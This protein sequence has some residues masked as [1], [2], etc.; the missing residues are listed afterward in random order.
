MLSY[1]ARL[2]VAC[3]IATFAASPYAAHASPLP[4]VS[5]VWLDPD[6]SYG[7][8]WTVYDDADQALAEDLIA[9]MADVNELVDLALDGMIVIRELHRFD[10]DTGQTI[11]LYKDPLTNLLESHNGGPNVQRKGCRSSSPTDVGVRSGKDRDQYYFHN[12]SEMWEVRYYPGCEQCWRTTK[13]TPSSQAYTWTDFY[14]RSGHDGA[15]HYWNTQKTRTRT[16]AVGLWTGDSSINYVH[17][18]C[19]GGVA[20]LKLAW[21]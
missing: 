7:F 9:N 17:R 1:F 20:K 12:T 2:L 8:V 21:Y 6:D 16:W 15:L 18:S 19:A 10:T 14:W 11:A 13:G 4:D 3:T 5:D